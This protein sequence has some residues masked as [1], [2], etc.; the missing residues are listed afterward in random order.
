MFAELMFLGGIFSNN[1]CAWDKSPFLRK[2]STLKLEQNVFGSKPVLITQTSMLL[3][4]LRH[5][6]GDWRLLREV[7]QKRFWTAFGLN[8]FTGK[9]D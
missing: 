6:F 1:W 9:K 7:R 3:A 2:L 4:T 8:G 5:S